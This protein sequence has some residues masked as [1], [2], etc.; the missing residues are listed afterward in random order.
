MPAL[1]AGIHVLLSFLRRLASR[2]YRILR[3]WNSDV[4]SN[5]AGVLGSHRQCI[6][7]N[8]PSPGS[9]WTMLRI[10]GS[11][12]TSPRTRGEVEVTASLTVVRAR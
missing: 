1:V 8:F 10:A 12:P 5:M 7:G 6:C 4:L 11:D 9:H 3:F 2:T